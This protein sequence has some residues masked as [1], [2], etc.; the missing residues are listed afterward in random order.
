MRQGS[1]VLG[2]LWV[3]VAGWAGWGHFKLLGAWRE[4]EGIQEHLRA[5]LVGLFVRSKL[6][7]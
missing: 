6:W 7:W 3:C 2:Y 1:D 4:P 5:S